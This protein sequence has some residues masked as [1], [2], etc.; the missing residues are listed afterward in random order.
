MAKITDIGSGPTGV[1]PH[2]V[3]RFDASP[4]TS[5]SIYAP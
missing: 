4:R 1:P 5:I 2:V 3:D